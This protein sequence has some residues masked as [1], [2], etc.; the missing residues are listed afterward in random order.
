MDEEPL[1][2]EP[3][4]PRYLLPDGCKGLI[5]VI[6]LQQKDDD[7]DLV[8]GILIGSEELSGD[9]PESIELPEFVTVRDLATALHTQAFL[10]V[11]VLMQHGFFKN[12][13]SQIDFITASLV[14]THY[15]VTPFKAP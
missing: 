6:R 7:E 1:E 15:G 4:K 13:N 2:S 10:V 9:P 12:V 3:E 11:K 14:C 5:D 8:S